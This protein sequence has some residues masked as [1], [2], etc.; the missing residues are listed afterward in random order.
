[1]VVGEGSRGRIAIRVVVGSDCKGRR[2][3]GSPELTNSGELG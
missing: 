3:M 1:M 2:R